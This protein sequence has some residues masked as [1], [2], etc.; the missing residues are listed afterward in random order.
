MVNPKKKSRKTPVSDPNNYSFTGGPGTVRLTKTVHKIELSVRIDGIPR[1]KYR[2]FSKTNTVT[3]KPLVYDVNKHHVDSFRRAM[4]EATAGMDIQWQKKQPMVL[5][6]KF[7]F[8]RPRYHYS[9][10]PGQGLVLNTDA[11]V[12]VVKTPDTD[13]L[14]KLVMDAMVGSLFEQDDRFIAECRGKKV[15]Y[16]P[17]TTYQASPVDQKDIGFT[18]LRLTQYIEGTFERGCDCEI[19]R[20]AKKASS[21]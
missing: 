1:P 6:C 8:G 10:I 4:K 19:C 20:A 3:N 14:L 16:S 12:Y 9:G 15:W 7:L 13:N 18:V 11:P 17:G 2:A 5:V 21:K